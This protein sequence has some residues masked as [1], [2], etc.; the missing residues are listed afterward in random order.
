MPGKNHVA[1]A[2]GM[3]KDFLLSAASCPHEVG[4]KGNEG[5]DSW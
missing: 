4:G 5:G 2:L 3:R 1:R